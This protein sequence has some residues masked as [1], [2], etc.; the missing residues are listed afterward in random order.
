MRHVGVHVRERWPSLVGQSVMGLGY[1]LPFLEPY[2]DEA[3]RS[4]AFMP[5]E[6]GVIHWPPR[7]EPSATAL[8]DDRE[9]PLPTGSLDRALLVHAVEN[10]HHPARC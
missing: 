1:A 8:V 3:M 5:A 9:L 2:R 10:S 7:G 4:F 6:Q